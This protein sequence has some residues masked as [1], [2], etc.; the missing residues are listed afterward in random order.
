MA[1]SKECFNVCAQV[2]CRKLLHKRKQ[3][4]NMPR[5][6]LLD[7]PPPDVR[8]ELTELLEECIYPSEPSAHSQL[9]LADKI[10]R[11]L[12]RTIQWDSK[13]R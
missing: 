4:R 12:A 10:K 8:K 11:V 2:I 13:P 6:G 1:Q 7:N 5:Q 9:Q 3:D